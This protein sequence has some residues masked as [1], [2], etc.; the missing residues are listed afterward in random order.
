MNKH[1][2]ATK[3]YI[4]SLCPLEVYDLLSKYKMPS[5][6]NYII[7]ASCIMRLDNFSARDYL[8]EK[9]NIHLS[10]WNYVVKLKQALQTFYK[11]YTKY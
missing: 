10:Y 4:K 8:A 7:E 11:S 5:V 2:R 9:Y 6:Y 3:E 1:N